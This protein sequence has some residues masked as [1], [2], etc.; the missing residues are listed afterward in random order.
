MQPFSSI[1]IDVGSGKDAVDLAGIAD[2]KR[3][4]SCGESLTGLSGGDGT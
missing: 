2:E 1:E 3:K 4:C